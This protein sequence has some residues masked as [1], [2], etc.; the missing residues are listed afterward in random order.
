M[1]STPPAGRQVVYYSKGSQSP[2][3]KITSP[4][5]DEE[6]PMTYQGARPKTS[7]QRRLGRFAHQEDP[8]IT[9]PVSVP[10]RVLSPPTP[11]TQLAEEKAKKPSKLSKFTQALSPSFSRKSKTPSPPSSRTRSKH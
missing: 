4:T 7:L 8:T 6:M 11:E 9:P 5:R 1:P 2:E 3:V 10:K